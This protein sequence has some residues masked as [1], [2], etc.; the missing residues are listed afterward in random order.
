M[1]KILVLVALFSS[2]SCKT[3]KI[4]TIGIKI[5]TGLGDIKIELYPDK[6]PV[7]CAN[8]IRY[9]ENNKFV[10]ANF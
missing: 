6:A 7:T 9:I 5:E 2:L 1:K 3:N 8:F 10:G 4:E